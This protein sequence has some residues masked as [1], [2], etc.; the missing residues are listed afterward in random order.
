VDPSLLAT[1]RAS[2]GNDGYTA[3]VEYLQLVADRAR[4]T[5]G[6]ILECGSGCSTLLLGLVAATRG[7]EVWS[8]EHDAQWRDR[9]TG[10]LRRL[11]VGGVR[12]VH[13]PLRSYGG[14]DWY[15]PGDATTLPDRFTL[16]VCDGPP[17]VSTRGGR[18]GLLPVMGGRFGPGTEVLLDDA[19]RPEEAAVLSRWATERAFRTEIDEGAGRGIARLIVA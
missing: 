19:A 7:V 5:G 1:F 11:G 3:P 14:F 2:W 13:A 17:S 4:N 18:Y 15:A 8:L 16:V 9:V 10:A 12:V 6:P